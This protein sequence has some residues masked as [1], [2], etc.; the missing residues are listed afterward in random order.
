MAFCG[1]I[2]RKAADTWRGYEKAGVLQG[3]GFSYLA[4]TQ[5]VKDVREGPGSFGG[6]GLRMWYSHN[7]VKKWVLW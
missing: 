1:L 7:A 4:E 3:S 5:R 6:S 2:S